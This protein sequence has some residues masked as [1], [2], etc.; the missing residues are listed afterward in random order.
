MFKFSVFVIGVLTGLLLSGG[1]LELRS[2]NL[3]PRFGFKKLVKLTELVL[4]VWTLL[5]PFIGKVPILRFAPL[6]RHPSW[7]IEFKT[8]A[9][10]ALKMFYEAFFPN[11][12]KVIPIEFL[13][14]YLDAVALAY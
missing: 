12:R 9:I 13:F 7:V 11:G 1:W 8:R 3:N 10:P 14:Y 2:A 5:A 4:H 6:N